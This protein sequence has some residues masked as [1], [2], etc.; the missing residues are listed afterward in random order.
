MRRFSFPVNQRLMKRLALSMG[1]LWSVWAVPASAEVGG[2]H[3]GDF[4][5]ASAP[6]RVLSSQDVWKR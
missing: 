6:I 1:V 3:S 2:V 5:D 4:V